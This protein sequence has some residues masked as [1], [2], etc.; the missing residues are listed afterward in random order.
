MIR[1]SQAY[2]QGRQSELREK[3]GFPPRGGVP[4]CVAVDIAMTEGAVPSGGLDMDDNGRAAF[5]RGAPGSA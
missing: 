1:S 4:L 3:F 2:L 5:R